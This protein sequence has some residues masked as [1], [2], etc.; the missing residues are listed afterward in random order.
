[1]QLY[2]SIHGRSGSY[3]L[4]KVPTF[5]TFNSHPNMHRYELASRPR[6]PYALGHS[7]GDDSANVTEPSTSRLDEYIL[8]ETGLGFDNP[9]RIN[10][11]NIP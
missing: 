10:V 6:P 7:L 3:E 2:F 8:P 4:E 11:F 9:V 1:M 5:R